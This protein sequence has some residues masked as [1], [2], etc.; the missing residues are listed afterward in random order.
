LQIFRPRKYIHDV[1]SD[2]SHQFCLSCLELLT[3]NTKN[4]C[5]LCQKKTWQ[6]NPLVE[7]DVDAEN[8]LNQSSVICPFHEFG[9]THETE[10]KSLKSHVISCTNAPT[11]CSECIRYSTPHPPTSCVTTCRCGRRVR[12][13]ETF[14]HNRVCLLERDVSKPVNNDA[15]APASWE[16]SLADVA[17]YTGDLPTL[18]KNAR[19]MEAAYLISLAN[20]AKRGEETFGKEVGVPNVQALEDCIGIWATA[21][22]RNLEDSKVRGGDLDSGLHLMLGLAIEERVLCEDLYPT[23]A[24]VKNTLDDNKIAADGAISDEVEGLL[25]SL[26]VP[27]KSSDTMKLKLI[28]QEYQRLKESGQSDQAAEVQNLYQWKLKKVTGDYNVKDITI[29]SSTIK[30]TLKKALKK[31]SDSLSIND[32]STGAN[33]ISKN[34]IQ[35]LN[36]ALFRLPDEIRV[37]ARRS[38]AYRRMM[39][40]LCSLIREY[41]MLSKLDTL[42]TKQFPESSCVPRLISATKSIVPLINKICSD[43]EN[44]SNSTEECVGLYFMWSNAHKQQNSQNELSEDI[45]KSIIWAYKFSPEILTSL[46]YRQLSVFDD[47]RQHLDQ[48]STTKFEILE[49]KL[50]EIENTFFAAIAATNVKV[51]FDYTNNWWVNI[52]AKVDY[53]LSQII[54]NF[55]QQKNETQKAK[56]NSKKVPSPKNLTEKTTKKL[57]IR[58]VQKIL[59]QMPPSKKEQSKTSQNSLKTGEKYSKKTPSSSKIELEKNTNQSK[60]FLD[61]S[62]KGSESLK[63][64]IQIQDIK[65]A[66]FSVKEKSNRKSHLSNIAMGE[67]SSKVTST[68]NLKSSTS[69]STTSKVIQLKCSKQIV[70]R[71]I[72]TKNLPQENKS[73]IKPKTNT[74]N[75]PQDLIK[76]DNKIT[77]IKHDSE[78]IVNLNA[79]PVPIQQNPLE[80]QP[81]VTL[82]LART[83]SR[84]LTLYANSRLEVP[85][86]LNNATKYYQETIS[87]DPY[88]PDAYIELAALLEQY[89][90]RELACNVYAQY[91]FPIS[92]DNWQRKLPMQDDLYMFGEI[93][94]LFVKEKR[95]EERGLVIS[96]VWLGRTGGVS[97]VQGFVDSLDSLGQ[98]RI[99]KEIFAG[100]NKLTVDHPDMQAF[101]KAKFWV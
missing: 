100:I 50:T 72:P 10:L 90:S 68:N 71:T 25:N 39:F 37:T 24:G 70:S 47:L 34:A 8:I 65:I 4:N 42:S 11:W 36:S 58:P 86:Y 75:P 45:I 96:L 12:V 15:W 88:S 20:A 67:S 23:V 89:T 51:K 27:L 30:F 18:K 95:F 84:R 59:K 63:N 7:S 19:E 99:L 9:C 78:K 77:E 64:Q 16:L 60:T 6:N 26:G 13:S 29:E 1:T 66:K 85:V 74:T 14:I 35:P 69:I 32:D 17:K 82:G 55:N 91:P 61:D 76:T 21:C 83:Y 101:F 53:Y 22:L 38:S 44:L 73:S 93:A 48:N 46:G 62:E 57:E 81:R 5:P 98:S 54:Q 28:E 92:A 49:K 3:D 41:V 33:L 40:D 43:S 52:Q 87:V 97:L 94:R 80:H 79:D 56:L 2:C 31:Y